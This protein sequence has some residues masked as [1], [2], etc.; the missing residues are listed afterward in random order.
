MKL[1]LDTD[2]YRDLARGLPEVISV[3]GSAEDIYLPIIVLAELRAGFL[4]GTR[5]RENESKLA[6]FIRRAHVHVLAP[7]E[8]TTQNY[9]AI[10]QQ[11]KR[12]GTPIP[13][14]DIWI[15]AMT[16]QYGLTLYARD[17]HFDHLLQL[18]RA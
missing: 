9:A 8:T 6:K 7:D 11:L 1:V 2:R 14:N 5:G 4:G 16:L 13:S 12:Q 3:I 15:A 10:Y 18:S 17:S